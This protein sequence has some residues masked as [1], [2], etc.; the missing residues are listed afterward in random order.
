M[1][2]HEIDSVLCISQTYCA[3]YTLVNIYK[4]IFVTT[5]VLYEHAFSSIIHL[6][7]LVSRNREALNFNSFFI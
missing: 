5:V 2:F 1:D 4:P 3:F 7:T 6:L